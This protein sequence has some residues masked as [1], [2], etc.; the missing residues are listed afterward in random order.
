MSHCCSKSCIKTLFQKVLMVN[1]LSP[2][3]PCSISISYRLAAESPRHQNCPPK[4]GL[5][6]EGGQLPAEDSKKREERVGGGH[7]CSVHLWP[8]GKWS[9]CQRND[10]YILK[11]LVSC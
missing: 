7:T 5:W 1:M 6:G 11:S 2:A 4:S 8:H 9:A 3:P 10:S